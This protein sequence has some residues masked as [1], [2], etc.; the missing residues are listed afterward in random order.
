MAAVIIHPPL[1]RFIPLL[2]WNLLLTAWP[3][4]GADTPL[5]LELWPSA[6]PPDENPRILGEEKIT[7]Y[8]NK[9]GNQQKTTQGDVTNHPDG[10][11]HETTSLTQF[12]RTRQKKKKI[13][14]KTK[15]VFK[16]VGDMSKGNKQR[17]KDGNHLNEIGKREG[18]DSS[19]QGNSMGHHRN[20]RQISGCQSHL[21]IDVMLHFVKQNEKATEPAYQDDKSDVSLVRK[22][23]RRTGAGP[24][25]MAHRFSAVGAHRPIKTATNFDQRSLPYLAG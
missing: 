11:A 10:D 17:G 8:G 13:M 20:H 5:G 22:A 1:C 24:Q 19:G 7:K 9:D 4:F 21:R 15:S 3:A 16:M 2:I 18:E 23:E 12:T 6:K 25:R 14:K